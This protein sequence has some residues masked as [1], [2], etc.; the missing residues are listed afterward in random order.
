MGAT[1][2]APCTSSSVCET[3]S[4]VREFQPYGG[5]ESYEIATSEAQA[6]HK[7]SDFGLDNCAPE[8]IA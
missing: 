2:C 1:T 3:Y 8:A 6:S 4:T 7:Y 5:S